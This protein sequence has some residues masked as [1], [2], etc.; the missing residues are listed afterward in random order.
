MS[1]S[2]TN[3][4]R[5]DTVQNK[6]RVQFDFS[7]KSLDKLDDLVDALGA[8]T[9][10]EVIRRALTVFTELLNAEQRGATLVIREANGKEKELLTIL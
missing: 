2:S 8:G 1:A 7:K 3:G 9:R 4:K 6:A 5:S 10:A